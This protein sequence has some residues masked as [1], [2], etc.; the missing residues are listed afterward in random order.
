MNPNNPEDGRD[1]SPDEIWA[2]SQDPVTPT[3]GGNQA[4]TRIRGLSTAKHPD[5]Y[6]H[7]YWNGHDVT[8]H[9][10]WFF[11][12]LRLKEERY[13]EWLYA[14]RH[15]KELNKQFPYKRDEEAQ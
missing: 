12:G 2:D 4:V 7:F 1:Y 9:W 5:G 13:C 14:K 3:V 11:S 15:G 6:Y 8:S 10:H